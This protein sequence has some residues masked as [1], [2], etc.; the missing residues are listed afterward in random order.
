MGG[1][2]VKDIIDTGKTMKTLLELLK[3]YNPKMV[4]VARWANPM[5][6]LCIYTHNWFCKKLLTELSLDT[7]LPFGVCPQSAGEE[8]AQKCRLQTRLWVNK[9]SLCCLWN[10]LIGH[11]IRYVLLQPG[12]QLPSEQISLIW[13]LHGFVNICKYLPVIFLWRDGVRIVGCKTMVRISCSTT[14]K[15]KFLHFI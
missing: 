11:F 7:C 2:F 1:F 12:W 10:V 14:R 3:Q 15:K 6:F 8:N 13:L 5:I 9:H 4:K